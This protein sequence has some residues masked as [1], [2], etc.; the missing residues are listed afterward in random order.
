MNKATHLKAL[1]HELAKQAPPNK[2]VFFKTG[3]G[4]YAEHDRFIGVTV[5]ILRKIAK[6]FAALPLTELQLLFESPINEER[7]LALVILVMQYQGSP[8][9]GK[10]TLYN[11]YISNLKHVNNWNLVDASAHLIIGDHLHNKEKD[12]LLTLAKS[13]NMW[14]RRIAMVATWHFIRQDHYEWTLKI[15]EI[16]LKDSHDLIHKAVGWMLREMG[17]RNLK[18][19]KAFLNQHAAL[20]PRTMLRYAIEKL[21]LDERKAYLNQGRV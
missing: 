4:G 11:F 16:L 7:L 12:I 13:D 21:P 2:A 18:T 8:H 10:I 20:M 14:E 5:P 3:V 19:L 9:D 17:K 1:L 15:A 6:Q